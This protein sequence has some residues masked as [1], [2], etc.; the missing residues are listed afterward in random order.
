MSKFVFDESCLSDDLLLYQKLCDLSSI[1]IT[2]HFYANIK[3]KEDLVSVGV[4]KALT[5]L[6][7]GY[8]DASK[9]KLMSFLYTGMRNEMHNYLYRI[10]REVLYDEYYEESY[11]DG[12]LDEPDI[13]ALDF[14]YVDEVCLFFSAYGDLRDYVI[15]NL[16]E[17]G[18]KVVNRNKSSIIKPGYSLPNVWAVRAGNKDEANELFLD[19]NLIALGWGK[20]G[21]MFNYESK[22]GIKEGLLSVFPDKNPRAVSG[23]ASQLFRFSFDMSVGDYAIYPSRGDRSIYLGKVFNNYEYNCG[24]DKNL[25]HVRNVRWIGK[26]PRDNFN[27]DTLNGMGSL[28]RFFSMNRY[29]RDLFSKI[30]KKDNIMLVNKEEEFHSKPKSFQDDFINRLSGAVL[31]KSRESFRL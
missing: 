14:K 21:N 15:M 16:E 27:Q 20:A 12:S 3:E 25:P 7:D 30:A 6:N 1:I 18:F 17:N 22:E 23:I 29:N 19:G 13:L 2:R 26:F 10:S 4:T 9:G 31:W 11:L 5:M 24:Y 28:L 8:W